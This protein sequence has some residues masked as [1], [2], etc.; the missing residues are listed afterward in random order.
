MAATKNFL[1]AKGKNA[2]AAVTKKRFVKLDSAAT[3]GETVKQCDTAGEAAF[4]VSEFDV[5]TAE[6]AKGKG[7]TCH[8]EGRAILEASEA[9]AVGQAVATTNDGRA[10]VATSGNYILGVCDEPA[11]GAGNECS[12]MLSLASLAKA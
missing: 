7:V 8:T 9:I 11:S 12:V 6:I 4:G 2:S 1:M 3:D 10:K 5:S